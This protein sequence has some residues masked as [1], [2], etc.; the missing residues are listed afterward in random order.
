MKCT[1]DFIMVKLSCSFFSVFSVVKVLL[2]N[3]ARI[4]A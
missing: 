4:P 2:F 1:E 3:C